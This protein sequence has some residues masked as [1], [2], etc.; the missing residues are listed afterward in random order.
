MTEEDI[1][2]LEKQFSII[3]PN[4]Y[5]DILRV[6]PFAEDSWANECAMPNDLGL[7]IEMNADRTILKEYGVDDPSLY[8]QIGSDGS[9][10]TYYIDSRDPECTVYTADVESGTFTKYLIFSDWCDDLHKTDVE[11]RRDQEEMAKK[12]WWQIWR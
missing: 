4:Q 3:L 11:I 12:K 10:L 7:I 6:Y 1:Q 9:E 5:R 2:T 8:F